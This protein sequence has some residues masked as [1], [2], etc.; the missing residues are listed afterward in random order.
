MSSVPTNHQ[1]DF[2]A[3]KRTHPFETG[4]IKFE[5]E[6]EQVPGCCGPKTKKK[7]YLGL[8]TIYP[9]VKKAHKKMPNSDELGEDADEQH[10]S[11]LSGLQSQENKKNVAAEG[12]E[13]SEK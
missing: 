7:A 2:A 6:T 3:I 4:N 9:F 5:K 13:V 1:I 11:D 12:E 8:P 10:L